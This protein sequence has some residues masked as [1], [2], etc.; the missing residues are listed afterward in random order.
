MARQSLCPHL[1]GYVFSLCS[2]W[3]VILILLRRNPQ[4][5][6]TTTRRLSLSAKRSSAFEHA[7]AF[8]ASLCIPH[9]PSLASCAGLIA[10]L[11]VL[12][13]PLLPPYRIH[14][15]RHSSAALRDHVHFPCTRISL[16]FCPR[17]AVSSPEQS[18]THAGPN[19]HD[20]HFARVGHDAVPLTPPGTRVA[21]ATLSAD[22]D[23]FA[24]ATTT[25]RHR[26][27]TEW[28]WGCGVSQSELGRVSRPPAGCTPLS[29]KG[30]GIATAVKEFHTRRRRRP[31]ARLAY[32]F[33]QPRRRSRF[34][35]QYSSC[36]ICARWLHKGLSDM[37]QSSHVRAGFE[38][39][40]SQSASTQRQS[41][42]LITDRPGHSLISAKVRS[43]DGLAGSLSVAAKAS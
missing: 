31:H 34:A 1:Q 4:T 29:D 30:A 24:A 40:C 37:D 6:M 28:E 36:L 2:F 7:A 17:L 23:E 25:P 27:R 41:R 13:Y 22:A 32:D 18:P 39:K 19:I 38:F 43:D 10:V 35:C 21:I 20:D 33:I 26:Q 9:R 3:D 14:L 12:C 8:I 16:R 5:M 42:D 15:Y 11:L